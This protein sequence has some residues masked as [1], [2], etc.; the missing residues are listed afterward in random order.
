MY[1]WRHLGVLRACADKLDH[2]VER[3]PCQH[4]PH[5]EPL[6]EEWKSNGPHCLVLEA[7]EGMLLEGGQR[8]QWQ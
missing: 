8:L 1:V 2:G 3:E 7:R 5:L 4:Q 6:G